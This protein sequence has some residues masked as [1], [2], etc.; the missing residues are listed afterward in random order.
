MINPIYRINF[1]ISQR[2]AP[3]AFATHILSANIN[4]LLGSK[5]HVIR[6]NVRDHV[7][8]DRHIAR[9]KHD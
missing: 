9:I 4:C 8:R 1:G 5:F 3:L 2:C 7:Y 6:I